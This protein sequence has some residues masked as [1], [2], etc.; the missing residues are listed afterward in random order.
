MKF[1]LQ[2]LASSGPTVA[3][4]GAGMVMGFSATLLP[5]LQKDESEI[6]ISKDIGSWIASSV[7]LPMS[8]GC[9]IGGWLIEQFGR[10]KAHLILSMPLLLGWLLIYFAQTIE[11]LLVGRIFGG[12]SVGL[13]GASCS[14]YLSE[15]SD[16]KF[17]GFFLGTPSM[18]LSVGILI[19]HVVGTFLTWRSTALFASIC[20]ILCFVLMSIVPETPSWLIS[21]DQYNDSAKAFKWLRGCSVDVQ[22]EFQNMCEKRRY[23][24]AAGEALPFWVQFRLN[25]Q[26]P[27]FYKPF[28][29]VFICFI[30]MQFTGPNT[31]TFYSITFMKQTIGGGVNEYVAMILIDVLRALMS[32]VACILLRLSPRRVLVMVSGIGTSISLFCLSAHI[33]L[34]K[35]FPELVEFSWM[36]LLFLV[37]YIFFVSIGIF[38]IPWCMAGE[39][40]PVSMRSFGSSINA[41]FNFIWCFIVVKT[42]PTMFESVGMD[43]TFLT[44]GL[45]CLTGTTL[46]YFFMPETKNKTLL[47]IEER[48]AK[49]TRKMDSI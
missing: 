23:A 12:L 49:K 37:S 46:L 44:Y 31:V 28:G 18:A 27:E 41:T 14:V 30:T 19:I 1:I 4:I 45:V 42:A 29:I 40:L 35:Y 39:L 10:K 8:V 38:P 24:K 21:K 22:Q 2:I 16:P 9:L 34:V 5:E 11:V 7:L 48:F 47:E 36:S 32:I 26:K 20:P 33:F 43:G 3:S 15:M 17:R 6:K 13:M 25:I